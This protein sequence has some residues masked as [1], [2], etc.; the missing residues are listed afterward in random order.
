MHQS[1]ELAHPLQEQDH[2]A[3]HL[4]AA[5]GAAGTTANK[6]REHQ[7]HGQEGGPVGVA[8]RAVARGRAKGD[9]LEQ[10]VVERLLPGGVVAVEQQG[11]EADQHQ[12][13]LDGQ[14]HL[15][16]GVPQIAAQSH[17]LV[18]EHHEMQGEVD[19]GQQQEQHSD[20]VDG[21]AVEETY[22]GIVSREAAHRQGGEG[23]ADGIEQ[24]HPRHP[25]GQGT[26]GGQQQV[27]EPERLGR[28]GDA[29]GHLVVLD[30]PRDLGAIE[31][32]A[33]DAEQGQNGHRQHYDPHASQP[34]QQLAI[35]EEGL[36]QAVQPGQ[37]CCPRGRQAGE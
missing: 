13:A 4:D 28:L 24:R 17:W 20:Q 10:A 31:L 19:A 34:L 2:E 16:F 15:Q 7:Q 29:R 6:G 36:R 30:R 12:H 18:G 3:H 14:E 37:H 26:E 21:R 9:R 27:D 1:L 22:A 23:V 11:Y 32:H 25:V 35:E 8:G 5:P 33:P